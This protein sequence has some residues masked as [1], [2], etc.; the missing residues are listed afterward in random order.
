MADVED[1][2]YVAPEVVQ[3]EKY[4]PKSDIYSLSLIGGVIFD[5][6]LFKRDIKKYIFSIEI[7]I[8]IIKL[9]LTGK[10]NY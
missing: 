3:C 7:L 2:R 8:F 5:M 1:V 4:G 10:Y 9:K 6:D